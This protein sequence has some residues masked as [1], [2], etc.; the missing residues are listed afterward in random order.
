MPLISAW[1]THPSQDSAGIFKFFSV[2]LNFE[3]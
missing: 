3:Q 2:E 1:N